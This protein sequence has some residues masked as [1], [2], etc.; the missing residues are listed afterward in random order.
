MEKENRGTPA[1]LILI[2]GSI[3][4]VD[5]SRSWAEAL[6]VKDGKIIFVGLNSL[7]LFFKG[8]ETIVYDLKGKMVLP[9]F[10]DSHVHPVVGG[11]E[12]GE[13]DLS[14]FRTED[15]MLDHIKNYALQHPEKEW[16]RGGGWQ[17]PLFTDGN[18]HK[19]L[20]DKVVA[21]RPVYLES[22][23]AH[24]AWVNS[25]ALSNAGI[26]KQTADPANGRIE[27]DNKT[28]IPSG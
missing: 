23:D 1:D 20:L 16:I 22:A 26:S 2:N 10:H 25:I 9:G 28:Q 21:D 5:A 27:R 15:Q 12:L 24:S 14:S 19:S 11:L 7:A 3:Y 17:L 4:T 13:C 8:P 18:P 6:A